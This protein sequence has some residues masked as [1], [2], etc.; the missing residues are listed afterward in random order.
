MNKRTNMRNFK[1]PPRRSWK[2]RSSVLLCSE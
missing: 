1:L 2:M